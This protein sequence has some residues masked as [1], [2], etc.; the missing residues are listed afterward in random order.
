M[1]RREESWLVEHARRKRK[2]GKECVN[3]MV[4]EERRG[5]SGGVQYWKNSILRSRESLPMAL[6]SER[7]SRGG[8]IWD[9]DF[10][11]DEKLLGK[12]AAS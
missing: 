11:I 3:E 1:Q 8:L 5:E 4:E 10:L 7:G 2:A 12:D 6:L 9:V